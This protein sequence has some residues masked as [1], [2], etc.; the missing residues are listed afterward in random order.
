[1]SPAETRID[2]ITNSAILTD[3]PVLTDVTPSVTMQCGGDVVLTQFVE[4]LN[5]HSVTGGWCGDVVAS[6]VA[7]R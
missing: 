1:M 7:N 4:A 6:N 5:D 3:S 2:F